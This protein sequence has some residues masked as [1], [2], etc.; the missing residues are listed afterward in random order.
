MNRFLRNSW[1]GFTART[2]FVLK[3]RFKFGKIMRFAFRFTDRFI[4]LVVNHQ[5]E[6]VLIIRN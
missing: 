4:A 6:D 1:F 5:S 3:V 2:S